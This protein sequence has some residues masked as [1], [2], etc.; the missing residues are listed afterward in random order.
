M[1]KPASEM[2][3]AEI[4][5]FCRAASAAYYTI[6]RQHACRT[7]VPAMLPEHLCPKD[8]PPSPYDYTQQQIQEAEEF[9]YRL[10]VI[11]VL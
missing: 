3:Q 2:T 6:V 9:L 8:R 11:G 1:S 7:G 4:N 5:D 10:G